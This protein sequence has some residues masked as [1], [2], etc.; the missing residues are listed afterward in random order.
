MNYNELIKRELLKQIFEKMSDEEKQTFVQLQM[1][2][3]NHNEIMD[4]LNS[5]K[6][7]IEQIKKKQNWKTDFLSDIAANFTTDGIIYLFSRL[8]RKL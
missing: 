3:K 5:Q 4:A 6:S 1:Q 7:D 2:S 8:L